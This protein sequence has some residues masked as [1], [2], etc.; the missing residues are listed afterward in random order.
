MRKA[1]FAVSRYAT[2]SNVAEVFALYRRVIGTRQEAD[3]RAALPG[4]F[5]IIDR[6]VSRLQITNSR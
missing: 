1:D 3:V 6:M 2:E 4:C 5:K